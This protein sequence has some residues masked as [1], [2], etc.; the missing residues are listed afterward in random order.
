M[1]ALRCDDC[2]STLGE[3]RDAD[4]IALCHRCFLRRPGMIVDEPAADTVAISAPV[5]AD[6]WL[7]GAAMDPCA[8]ASEPVP[9]LPGFPFMHAAAGAVMSGPTGAGRSSLVQA[10]AYD[11]SAHGVRVAYLGSEVTEEE[12]NARAADLAVRRGDD[13]D[14]ELRARLSRVRYL[15]LTSVIAHAWQHPERWTEDVVDRFDLVVIDPLSPVAS[16]L[17]LDFDKSN[18]EFVRFYDRFVQP[19]VSAGVA[20]LLLDNIGHALEARNRAKGASAKQDRADLTFSCKLK[21]QPV[22]LVVTAGKVRS[23]R[24]PFKR[25]DAWVFDRDTQRIHR[26]SGEDA[27][28]G[29]EHFRPTVLMERV[30]RAIEADPGLT[31]RS[32]RAAVKGKHD[33]KELALDCLIAEGH[34]ERDDD[35][36]WPTHRSIHPFRADEDTGPQL[37]P[38]WPPPPEGATGPLAPALKGQGPGATHANGNGDGPHSAIYDYEELSA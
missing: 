18:A 15:N 29:G 30:S 4:G 34:V 13:V 20:V 26:D 7:G 27:S 37:A 12:F 23:V 14:D 25:G 19:I 1:N 32:L 11:A 6:D 33:A 10:C 2:G 28:T 24:A 17:G 8:V 3:I 38:D 5:P 31:R 21:A 16:V 35:Q 22:G 9:A 36:R